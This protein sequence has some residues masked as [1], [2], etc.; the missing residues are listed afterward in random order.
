MDQPPLT[1]TLVSGV[2]VD[3]SECTISCSHFGVEHEPTSTD[4]YKHRMSTVKN[5]NIMRDLAQKEELL[6]WVAGYVAK[7]RDNAEWVS[8]E[9]TIKK[10]SL[11]F[12]EIFW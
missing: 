12:G 5:Q 4:E 3:I 9:A 10:A 1:S 6:K 11:N 8:G 2:P 7:Q